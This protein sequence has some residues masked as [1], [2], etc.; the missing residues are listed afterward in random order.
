MAA[1]I[2]VTADP[3]AHRPQRACLLGLA[4]IWI[5]LTIIGCEQAR[6]S[7]S[8]TPPAG[9]ADAQ[10]SSAHETAVAA[11]EQYLD[12][13][14]LASAET[15]L[16][17]LLEQA[18]ANH[19]AHE[20][21]GRVLYLKSLTVRRGGDGKSG[22]ALIQE[23]YR[24][25]RASVEA[26]GELDAE[27]AAGLNQS[28]GEIA[29]AAGLP[30]R[31]A[32]HFQAAGRLDPTAPKHP[33]YEAQVLIQLGRPAEARRALERVL[34]LDPD[35]AYAHASLAAV[36][37]LEDDHASALQHIQE[38]REIA[39]G[40]LGIRIQEARI[41][42]QCDQPRH[43]LE[44]LLALDAGLRAEEAVT[45]ELAACYLALDQP[46]E[47]ARVWERRYRRGPQRPTAWRAAVGAAHSHLAAGRR[48]EAL[49]WYEQARL[50]A[51]DQPEVADLGG[52]RL[53]ARRR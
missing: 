49:W 2:I 46:L 1:P 36:A 28:A 51:P 23:A 12:G 29:S 3:R 13:N 53:P 48:E 17:K 30:D 40:N 47:A 19:R 25:Y 22:D 52:D 5:A 24:H 39:P 15:I 32:E 26:A 50:A 18:P 20:L 35:E 31:A 27:V 8:A 41:R 10:R 44:L 34:T 37:L 11:A 42:R 33:L 21:L 6:E 4:W 16:V 38:A 14:D 7:E 9:A 45:A 43:A